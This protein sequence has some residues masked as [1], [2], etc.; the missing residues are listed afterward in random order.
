V[1]PKTTDIPSLT[2]FK[3]KA[4]SYP[5]G[6]KFKAL[7]ECEIDPRAEGCPGTEDDE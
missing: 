4:R 1:N 7:G 5:G 2:F 6:E 3:T